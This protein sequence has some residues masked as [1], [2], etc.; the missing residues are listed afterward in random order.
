VGV[1]GGEREGREGRVRVRDMGTLEN[2][3]SAF[4]GE[5]MARNRYTFYASIAKEEGFVFISKV[6]LETAE[7]EKEHA[8]TL[9]K[10]IQHLKGESPT[11]SV[12]AGSSLVLGSTAENLKSAI[13]GERHEH[14]KM[15][16][17]FAEEAEREGLRE[18]A[19]RLRAI[20]K[21]EEHHEERFRK[22]YE[23]LE[24]GEMFKRGEEVAWVC[25]ECGYIHYGTEPPEECPSCGHSKAYYVARD[26]LCL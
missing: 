7:N 6:F 10:L 4:V 16:P 5:S 9:F 3:V 17:E 8:E 11:V 20:A 25:L 14:T 24:S 21:A 26:M 22:I 18:I 23:A 2:L 1:G 19:E 13:E 15:Y 12:E